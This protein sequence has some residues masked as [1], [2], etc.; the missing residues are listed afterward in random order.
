MPDINA[1]VKPEINQEVETPPAINED[2]RKNIDQLTTNLIHQYN[3]YR[4]WRES[5]QEPIWDRIYDS[6]HGLSDD[7]NFPYASNYK[8][9][10]TFRQIETLKPQI[11]DLLLPDDNLFEYKSTSDANID[12]ALAATSIVHQH[13]ETHKLRGAIQGWLDD[14]IQWGT[15]YL[16]FGWSEYEDLERVIA[17]EHDIQDDG[18]KQWKRNSSIQVKEGPKLRHLNHWQVYTDPFTEDL[19]DSPYVFVRKIVSGTWCKQK[20]VEGHFDK[21][22]VQKLLSDTKGGRPN[23]TRGNLNAAAAHDMLD[24]DIRNIQDNSEFELL[25]CYTNN[26]WVYSVLQDVIVRAQENPYDRAPILTLRNYPQTGEHYG[27]SEAEVIY[28][29]QMLVDDMASMWVDTVHTTLNPAWIV[30]ATERK[31]WSI[32]SMRPGAVAYFNNIENIKPVPVTPTTF[33][34]QNSMGFALQRM[35]LGTGVTDETSGSS[36]Q[37]TA[38]GIAR[39]QDA[40]GVRIRHKVKYFGPVFGELYRIIYNLEGQ[41]LDEEVAVRLE[42]DEATDSFKVFSP[43]VFSGQV[44]VQVVTPN[45][46]TSPQER[47]SKWA[48]LW[49]LIGQDPRFDW[50]SVALE[51]LRA[52]EIK[53][54]RRAIANPARIQEDALSEVKN[55]LQSG[56]YPPTKAYD[57]H[58]THIDMMDMIESTDIFSTLPPVFQQNHM[59]HKQE[60]MFYVQQQ[61]QAAG[62]LAQVDTTG[63]GDEADLRTEA[64]FGN[65]QTGAMQQGT[66]PGDAI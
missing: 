33:E 3:R 13:I 4:G 36:K 35:Q 26:G 40:A 55:F 30:D 45:T 25:T 29:D 16:E 53:R 24:E 12:D 8:I 66:Q 19:R 9:R 10:E 57:S 7:N 60:H 17:I 48:S 21:K 15:S 42:G 61:Q 1:E 28:G 27:I 38:S 52:Y 50:E 65:A 14:A 44:D 62:Q 59:Y 23:Q 49:Q 31:N 43:L 46:L 22:V 37:R 39:L 47:Q 11:S 2:A 63:G 20:I 18:S 51:L 5:N 34:I 58:Q 56:V 54:P 32:T 64:Q 41:F 6:Y